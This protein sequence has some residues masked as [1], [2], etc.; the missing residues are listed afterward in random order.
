[1]E[2]KNIILIIISLLICNNVNAQKISKEEK[3]QSKVDFKLLIEN[4]SDVEISYEN[5]KKLDKIEFI[6]RSSEYKNDIKLINKYDLHRFIPFQHVF[7]DG[8]KVYMFKQGIGKTYPNEKNLDDY[9]ESEEILNIYNFVK[10]DDSKCMIFEFKENLDNNKLQY[11]AIEL[12]NYTDRMIFL[13]KQ[14]QLWRI[15]ENEEFNISFNTYYETEESCHEHAHNRKDFIVV[16]STHSGNQLIEDTYNSFNDK[17]YK[18]SFKYKSKS[19]NIDMD[20]FYLNF[21][22]DSIKYYSLDVIALLNS[23]ILKGSITTYWNKLIKTQDL[24]RYYDLEERIC[25]DNYEKGSILEKYSSKEIEKMSIPEYWEQVIPEIEDLNKYMSVDFITLPMSINA[26]EY[27]N[28][29][30][31]NSSEYILSMYKFDNHRSDNGFLQGTMTKCKDRYCYNCKVQINYEC[32]LKQYDKSKYLYSSINPENIRD[33]LINSLTEMFCKKSGVMN[34]ENKKKEKEEKY[35]NDLAEKYGLKY[36][37]AA[38]EGDIIIGMPE[39]LLTIPLRAWNIDS[40]SEWENGYLIYCK[41][42]FDTSKRIKIIVRN[43]KVSEV[44]KW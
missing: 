22:L 24:K 12:S 33:E 35:K 40:S 9:I 18:K 8:K 14:V 6:N 2:M 13:K 21:E 1:M 10:S 30:E 3:K 15:I 7:N 25:K 29:N 17:G 44:S 43:G 38:L 5:S 23:G 27:E 39:D 4:M 42:K 26:M 41:F 19:F 20:Y 34:S 28:N 11:A 16:S 32:A 36:V 37:E 31:I